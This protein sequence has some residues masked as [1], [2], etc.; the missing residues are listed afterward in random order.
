MCCCTVDRTEQSRFA[1]SWRMWFC[2]SALFR[3]FPTP[4]EA[5]KPM[6]CG[7]FSFFT[8]CARLPSRG[9]FIARWASMISLYGCLL[10]VWWHSSNISKEKSVILTR[11]DFN[12]STRICAVKT[13]ISFSLIISSSVLSCALAPDISVISYLEKKSIVYNNLHIDSFV[14]PPVLGLGFA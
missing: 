10:L 12:A 7:R 9:N 2:A 14:T 3:A 8:A 11:F 5:V 1:H 4:K 13:I 6:I